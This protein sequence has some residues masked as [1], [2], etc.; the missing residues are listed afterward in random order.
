MKKFYLL[1]V[2]TVVVTSLSAQSVVLTEPYKNTWAARAAI[3]TTPIGQDDTYNYYYLYDR[4][5]IGIKPK[6]YTDHLYI[7]NKKSLQKAGDVALTVSNR[8]GFLGGLCGDRS[9]Y[10]LYESLPGK[11]DKIV[12]TL[13]DLGK[14]SRTMTLS[15]DNSVSTTA[16][17]KFWPAFKTAK[18]PDGK[19]LAAL[20]VVTGKDSRLENL[21]AVVVNNQGEFVWN[22]PVDA[23][24]GGKTFS[25]GN[26]AVDNEGTLYMPAYT[27]LV[28]GKNVSNVQF[29]MIR[30]NADGSSSFTEDVGFG[31]PQ[32]FT[33]KVLAN[34]EVEVAG[35]YTDSKTTTAT[36]T[37][38]Y[39][40]YR[41]DPK[42]ESI[43]DIKSF[44][45]ND[46]YVEK[47]TWVR[48][49]NVLGNQQYSVSADNIFELEDGSLV[50]CGEHRFVKSVYN[51]QMN[52]T[53]YQMLT[54]NILVSTLHP[55]GN[56]SFTMI[57]KQQ[58]SGQYVVPGDDWRSNCISYT[59]FP[60]HNDMYFLFSDDPKNIPYPGK[61][62]VCAPGGITFKDSWTNVLMRLT[63]DQE[64]I[65]RVIKDPKQLLRSVDFTD[66]EYFITTGVGKSELYLNKY[67]IEE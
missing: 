26:M 51:Q 44:E 32:N 14:K 64:I 63:P 48:F 53:T 62:V 15:D 11:G 1:A 37:S 45:F 60:H 21:Y 39:Y 61:G 29:M 49:A 13:A 22:G 28:T 34:G 19:L 27:C 59:A 8:H 66:D 7:V 50:L 3:Y 52:S 18:S 23:Q 17:P 41:F 33:A 47:E 40:F 24:F 6:T 20:A 38:G 43:T 31:T 35:Y 10:V 54:K 12:F 36:Q 65:Q 25:L 42:S 58:S 9:T 5:V 56:A 4:N 46:G 16:N 55:D 30:T 67:K 2:L 57:E